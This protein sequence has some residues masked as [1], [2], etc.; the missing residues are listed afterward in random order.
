MIP[1][2]TPDFQST[3]APRPF[4]PGEFYAGMEATPRT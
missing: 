1:S 3:N 4:K 2:I